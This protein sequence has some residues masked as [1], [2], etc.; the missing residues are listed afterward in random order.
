MQHKGCWAQLCRDFANAAITNSNFFSIACCKTL[1]HR[2]CEC[3]GTFED[4]WSSNYFHC[5]W[6]PVQYWH[7]FCSRYVCALILVCFL[8]I[9]YLSRHA[10]CFKL[11]DIYHAWRLLKSSTTFT[12]DLNAFEIPKM[13]YPGLCYAARNN[14][15]GKSTM[16]TIRP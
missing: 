1:F 6:N 8:V 2:T 14:R 9:Q 11:D 12:C 7:G 16:L 13:L 3:H 10:V 4:L 15:S 5:D